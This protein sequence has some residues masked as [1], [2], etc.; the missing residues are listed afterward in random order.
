[1]HNRNVEVKG[2]LSEHFR[3]LVFDYLVLS[4]GS[5]NGSKRVSAN[6]TK[7]LLV[8]SPIFLDCII[9]YCWGLFLNSS[10]KV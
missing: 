6:K 3:F 7:V 2:F 1:M 4:F 10:E 5:A 8:F 9:L